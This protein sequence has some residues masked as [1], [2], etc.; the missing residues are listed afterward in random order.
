MCAL[1]GAAGFPPRVIA[2]Y[3]GAIGFG[4]FLPLLWD[5]DILVIEQVARLLIWS[6]LPRAVSM[7]PARQRLDREELRVL[8]DRAL[9]QARA[10]PLTG[11]GNRRAFDEAVRGA[12]PGAGLAKCRASVC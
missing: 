1:S 9:E 7:L 8:G 3:M 12:G 2:I 11:L 6:G 10:D 5:G 4:L